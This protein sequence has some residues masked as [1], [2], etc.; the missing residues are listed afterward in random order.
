MDTVC[1][2]IEES[3]KS[4]I[5]VLG[6]CSVLVQIRLSYLGGYLI[7]DARLKYNTYGTDYLKIS[8]GIGLTNTL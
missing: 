5:N 1:R 4:P 6:Q 7:P 8:V 2:F 3:D